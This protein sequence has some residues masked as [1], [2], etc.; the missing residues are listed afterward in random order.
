MEER[1]A[2]NRINPP[3]IKPI[4][5]NRTLP[6]SSIELPHAPLGAARIRVSDAH[7]DVYAEGEAGE[8]LPP[9]VVGGALGTHRIEFLETDG[10]L[11]DTEI[12]DVDCQSGIDNAEGRLRGFHD[13]LYG[14]VFISHKITSGFFED[15][16]GATLEVL[17]SVFAGLHAAPGLP[18]DRSLPDA[19]WYLLELS[20]EFAALYRNVEI[21]TRPNYQPCE[22]YTPTG[23]PPSPKPKETNY[24][25]YGGSY[26]EFILC[27]YAMV[28]Q[29]DPEFGRLIRWLRMILRATLGVPELLNIL[30]AMSA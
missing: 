15:K 8:K 9:V 6:L 23:S 3:N 11:I 29:L 5:L 30:M 22:F 1:G 13:K 19:E 10:R 12:F 17:F 18:G 24:Q 27:Y 7:G 28:T 2:A 26:K 16:P 25:R 20:P 21:P 4:M 14:N